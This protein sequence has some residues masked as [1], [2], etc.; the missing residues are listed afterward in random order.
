MRRK[1]PILAFVEITIIA[2]G[3]GVERMFPQWSPLSWFVVAGVA[4]TMAVIIAIWPNPWNLQRHRDP[5]GPDW[6]TFDRLPLKYAACLWAG[7]QPSDQ[8]LKNHKTQEILAELRLAVHHG[9]LRHT[10]GELFYVMQFLAG[11]KLYVD[12]D[13]FP[14][15]ELN[16]Y[17]TKTGRKKLGTG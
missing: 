17:A 8:S 15:E 13:D 10:L 1:L 7:L 16:R 3:F 12:D 9:K 4:L 14:K 2:A 11:R 6:A 5:P